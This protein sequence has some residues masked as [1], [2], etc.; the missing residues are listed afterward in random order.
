MESP[1]VSVL[2]NLY[3]QLDR[4]ARG[5]AFKASHAVCL[6]RNHT[7]GLLIDG[8]PLCDPVLDANCD[9]LGRMALCNAAP[10]DAE[11][12]PFNCWL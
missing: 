4:H 9:S 11:G 7:S 10:S 6:G 1:S 3:P 12:I 8:H 5:T 2:F